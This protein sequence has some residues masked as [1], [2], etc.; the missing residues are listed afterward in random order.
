M[1]ET[2]MVTGGS[3]FI[4]SH[5]VEELIH[6]NYNVIVVDVAKPVTAIGNA[7]YVVG[8]LLDKEF[9]N[10]IMEIYSPV[11]VL[12]LAGLPHI[13]TCEADPDRS[14]L[15]NTVTTHNVLEAMRRNSV[16][17]IVFAS[18]GAV[19]GAP[20]DKPI[21]EDTTPR[22][23]S[24]YGWHKYESEIEIRAYAERYGI[25]GVVLRLFNVYG[26]DP[27]RGKDVI[28]IFIRNILNN[29]EII[30]KGPRKFRDFIFVKDVA[31]AFRR[32]LE[33][34]T[35]NYVVIN[36]GTGRK[37]TL[38][39]LVEILEK[40][41][42]KKAVRREVADPEDGLGYYADVERMKKY[43]GIEPMP[44]TEGIHHYLRMYGIQGGGE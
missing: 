5:V 38:S 23:R 30:L 40:A 36:I 14:Y 32:A 27:S 10:R 4:G 9:V 19:Y 31:R 44:I 37:T 35:G 25:K 3:G 12:H 26:N 6:H 41:L 34:D 29:K 24:I 18:T 11:A 16:E 43:L 13:P 28:S 39:E 15:V 7:E 20:S 22:P 17:K 8:D 42:G 2:I 33:A 21:S 1:L